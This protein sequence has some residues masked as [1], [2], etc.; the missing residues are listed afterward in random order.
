MLDEEYS[1]LLKDPELNAKVQR[2]QVMLHEAGLTPIHAIF[3]IALALKSAEKG[4]PCGDVV[5]HRLNSIDQVIGYFLDAYDSA[6]P[7]P[8]AE[9]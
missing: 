1:E 3:A 4:C 8:T 2:V 6:A 7:K 9:V 5:L